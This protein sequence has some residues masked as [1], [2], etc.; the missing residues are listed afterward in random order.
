MTT[1]TDAPAGRVAAPAAGCLP[2]PAA[3][4]DIINANFTN[5][6]HLEH[7]QSVHG[8]HAE[9]YVGGNIV[10]TAGTKVSSQDT[11]VQ[12]DG[13]VYALTSDARRYTLLP[14]G[15]RLETHFWD[16]TDYNDA[17]GKCVGDL[18][19]AQNAGR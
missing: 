8:T 2:A 10:D 19:R 9:T 6:E 12:S 15:R 11:W 16:W 7:A 17:V 5:G 18:E 4:V 14:D 3:I 1:P 13:A